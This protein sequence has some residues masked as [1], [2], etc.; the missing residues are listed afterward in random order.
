MY[1][2]TCTNGFISYIQCVVGVLA[3]ITRARAPAIIKKDTG[4]QVES[5]NALLLRGV[6]RGRLTRRAE[7]SQPVYYLGLDTEVSLDS[8]DKIKRINTHLRSNVGRIKK[9][10]RTRDEILSTLACLGVERI[11]GRR[12]RFI[13][14]A[15]ACQILEGRRRRVTKF[16]TACCDRSSLDD[17]LN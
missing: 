7:H 3:V 2:F 17:F 14:E 13:S 9:K 15:S 12:R 16:T 10:T 6:G 8:R 5:R 1:A 11:Q 4:G